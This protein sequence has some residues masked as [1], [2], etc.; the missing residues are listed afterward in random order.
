MVTVT[1]PPA[2]TEPTANAA[3]G[4]GSFSVESL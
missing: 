2:N 1:C 4:G 3:D